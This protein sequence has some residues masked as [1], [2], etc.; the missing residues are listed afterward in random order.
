MNTVPMTAITMNI[1]P[2]P[3]KAREELEVETALVEA[4]VEIC[5]D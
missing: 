1:G 2:G 4:L 3:V 5:P